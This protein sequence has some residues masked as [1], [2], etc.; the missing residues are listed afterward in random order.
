[1]SLC[2]L[3]GYSVVVCAFLTL[4]SPVFAQI[5][6]IS[7]RPSIIEYNSALDKLIL[8]SAGPNQLHIYDPNSKSDVAVNLPL[9][10]LSLSLSPDGQYAAVGHD[11]YISYINLGAGSLVRVYSVSAKVTNLVLS[12]QYVYVLPEKTVNLATGSE[13]TTSTWAGAGG[14]ARMHPSGKSIYSTRGGSPN[15]VQRFDISS[16][17]LK[18][19]YDSPYHG[20]H[21][22]CENVWFSADGARIFNSCATVFHASDTKADDLIYFGGLN[23]SARIVSLSESVALKK[24][25]AISN[26]YY[27]YGPLK[28]DDS[29][30][31][32][33]DYDYLSYAGKLILPKFTV[34]NA[35]FAAHGKFVTFSADSKKLYVIIQADPASGLNNDF[36]LYVAQWQPAG[37]CG[38]SLG[39]GSTSL[40]ASASAATIPVTAT[41]DCIWETT[42]NASWISFPEGRYGMGSTALSYRSAENLSSSR[43]TSLAFGTVSYSINQGAAPA[44]VDP[45]VRLPFS[46]IAAEYS[47][48]LDSIVAISSASN[49]LHIFNPQTRTH[50]TVPLA[51]P[52]SSVALSPSGDMAAVGHDGWVSYVNIA[53]ATVQKIYKVPAVAGNL[54]IANYG[55]IYLFPQ[56]DQWEEIHSIQIA[57]GATSVTGS[58][59][60]GIMAALHPSGK[61][62]YTSDS[63]MEKYDITTGTPKR[64]SMNTSA[65]GC[66]RVWFFSDG[67]RLLT[68]CG[69][70]L[71]SSEIAE[72]DMAYAGTLSQSQSQG[73]VLAASHSGRRNLLAVAHGWNSSPGQ[74]ASKIDYYG[75]A[76]LGHEGN[77]NLPPFLSDGK[78]YPANVRWLFWSADSSKL[79]AI[80]KTESSARLV[81]DSA[82]YTITPGVPPPACSYTAGAAA[83]TFGSSGGT[84]TISVSAT[85]GCIWQA[86]SDVSWISVT[87]GSPGSGDGQATFTV[88]ANTAPTSRSGKIVAGGQII[89]ISQEAAAPLPAFTGDLAGIVPTTGTGAAG[90]FTATFTHSGGASQHYLGYILFLPTPNIVWFTARGSCLIEYNRISNGMRLINDAGDNWIG[91][92]SGVPVTPSAAPLSNSRCTV[93]VSNSV[94]QVNGNTMTVQVRVSFKS[95]LTPVLGTFLQSL[96]VNGKWTDMRQFGNWVPSGAVAQPGISIGGFGPAAIVGSSALY[97]LQVNHST[98]LDRVGQVHLRFSTEIVKG[99]PC[100]VIFFPQSNTLNLVNDSGTALVHPT[101]EA[102]GSLGTISNS[103]CTVNP[104]GAGKSAN[105]KLMTINV[106]VSFNKQNFAGPKNI[107]VNA[108]DNSGGLTHWV[109]VGTLNVQ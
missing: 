3:S 109:Q 71:R 24:I 29:E 99:T 62:F 41:S 34:G 44:S 53:A 5:T 15:D 90:T 45:L 83:T 52:S 107:Y 33:Y 11:A 38:I 35:T 101:G 10:P 66:G 25:V 79:F 59:Y 87:S 37:N 85:A 108:F 30:I 65:S 68:A 20:D 69:V 12:S 50:R 84:G 89:T 2:R 63:W 18:F 97:S 8:V 100:H 47:S 39:S 64:L 93:H 76:F 26:P 81:A 96:D 75:D 23:R 103:Y 61:Y 98:N 74:T 17:A 102:I 70:V 92:I 106:P 57:T 82:V 60:A 7:F 56:R 21:P 19:E 40:P 77:D 13:S 91:P 49:Y 73:G 14:A 86:I 55:Y 95:A 51:L 4:T 72:Q 58:I 16:G 48:S 28:V 32:V 27:S 46:P 80:A 94:G 78:T 88:L 1:M 36:A 6:P 104:A 43:T 9:P 22:V 31:Q 54:L 42:T 67:G 105:G